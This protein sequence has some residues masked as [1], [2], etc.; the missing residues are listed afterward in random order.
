M[1]SH[2]NS[3]SYE[4][5][6]GKPPRR[7]QFQK[8]RSGNPGGRPRRPPVERLKKLALEEAYRGVIVMEYGRAEPVPAIQAILR[9][10]IE[11]AVAGNIRAQR[12]ILTMIQ[13]I[14]RTD[15]VEAK[16]AD[17]YDPE[18]NDDDAETDNAEVDHDDDDAYVDEDD[19]DAGVE[20]QA[21]E[22]DSSDEGLSEEEEVTA[23]PSSDSAPPPEHAAA[24]AAVHQPGDPSPDGA[25]H[26]ASGDEQSLPRRNVSGAE[27]GRGGGGRRG[28]RGVYRRDRRRPARAGQPALPA[29]G[30]A[31]LRS[32]RR[33]KT[34]N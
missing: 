29:G 12:A 33:R 34:I 16:L 6:Y 21:E 14:E 5:G 2:A 23:P 30:T 19:G 22:V 25:R 24:P 20:Q 10:Q 9:S 4:V 17:L 11:L 15:A 18:N 7:T 3:A 8:G 28:A 32:A 27:R 13:D 31:T 1:T 26:E